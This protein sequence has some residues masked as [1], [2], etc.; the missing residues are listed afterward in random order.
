METDKK[1]FYVSP[2]VETIEVRT[3]GTVL[4]TSKPDNYP[5]GGNP[6]ASCYAY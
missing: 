1:A 2:D 5:N 3:E 4:T 6:F